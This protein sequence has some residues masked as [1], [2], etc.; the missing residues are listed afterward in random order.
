MEAAVAAAA[1]IDTLIQA[2]RPPPPPA[3]LYLVYPLKGAAT[4]KVGHLT[5]VFGNSL[6]HIPLILQTIPDPSKLTIKISPGAWLGS[7]CFHGNLAH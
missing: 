7:L 1:A 4:L 2:T 6:T 5:S 3:S